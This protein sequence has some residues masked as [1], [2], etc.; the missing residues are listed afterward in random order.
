MI[1]AAPGV[2]LVIAGCSCGGAVLGIDDAGSIPDGP[3]PADVMRP[4]DAA[5]PDAGPA[6]AD[7]D[8]CA[9]AN[10]T[11]AP[12]CTHF[13]TI[14]MTVV[15]NEQSFGVAVSNPGEL[16]A[17]IR[18][19]GWTFAD[20]VFDV[21]PG[22]VHVES[23]GWIEPLKNTLGAIPNRV[24]EGAYVV[25]SDRPVEVVEYSPLAF[26]GDF[27]Q[28]QASATAVPPAHLLGDRYLVLTY[29]EFEPNDSFGF[30]LITVT[31]TE[32]DSEVTLVP[33]RALRMGVNYYFAGAPATFFMDARDVI[34][35]W[36][37]GDPTGT[38]VE[39]NHP[40]TVTAGSVETYAA[41]GDSY[42]KTSEIVPP[43]ERAGLEYFIVG[44]GTV[45]EPG[46]VAEIVRVMA[47]APGATIVETD[48]PIAGSPW[49]LGEAEWIEVGPIA[50]A[51]RIASDQPILVAQIMIGGPWSLV[52]DTAGGAPSMVYPTPASAYRT[53][54]GFFAPVDLDAAFADVFAPAGASLTF[55]GAAL[56]QSTPVGS[57]GWTHRRVSLDAGPAGDGIHHVEADAPIGVTVHAIGRFTGLW[58]AP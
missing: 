35:L 6:D 28:Q 53:T 33:T 5:M 10:L 30:P 1:R 3:A 26:A 39:S 21:A 55:D 31:A 36:A 25:S 12:G 54:R 37:L 50:G 22:G 44:P 11:G 57:S 9:F 15:P 43:V 58:F 47:V 34:Q 49:T 20:H 56:I 29:H 51:Y 7:L 23:L 2:A 19:T 46:G 45:P 52:Y 8:P 18:I 4:A 38:V 17:A 24:F 32:D 14:T 13:A 40:V 48:P 16:T 42:D 41:A 27:T